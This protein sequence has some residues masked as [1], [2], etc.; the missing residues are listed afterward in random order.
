MMN[1]ISESD[2][3]TES[4]LDNNPGKI[5]HLSISTISPNRIITD[6]NNGKIGI[7]SS[8]TSVSLTPDGLVEIII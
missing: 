6:I 8:I 7:Q 5:I 1:N 4:V 2:V 3:L